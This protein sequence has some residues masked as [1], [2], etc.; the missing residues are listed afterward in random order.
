MEKPTATAKL[1]SNNQITLPKAIRERLGVNVGDIVLF[2]IK[3][4]E[5]VIRAKVQ[6]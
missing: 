4:E 1:T 6:L 2:F 3:D 5:I